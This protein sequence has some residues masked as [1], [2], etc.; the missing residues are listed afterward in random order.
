MF[1]LKNCMCGGALC[2][3][4][5]TFENDRAQFIGLTVKA[6]ASL[7]SPRRSVSGSSPAQCNSLCMPCSQ[8]FRFVIIILTRVMKCFL[9]H[10]FI[11]IYI[12]TTVQVQSE[13]KTIKLFTYLFKKTY[14]IYNIIINL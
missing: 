7:Q 6:I 2:Y 1:H 9:S 13:K 4:S 8:R 11:P 5:G 3:I 10:G 14:F 12:V